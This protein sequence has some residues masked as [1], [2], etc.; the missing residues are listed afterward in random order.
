MKKKGIYQTPVLRAVN[1]KVDTPLLSAS[2]GE[3]INA[4]ISGYQKDNND[5][6]YGFSQ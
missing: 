3:G 2:N 5:D 6:D 1:L 4:T